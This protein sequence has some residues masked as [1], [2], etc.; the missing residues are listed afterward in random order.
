MTVFIYFLSSEV[1]KV[2]INSDAQHQIEKL[3]DFA[4]F[5]IRALELYDSVR[6]ST[7]RGLLMGELH[8]RFQNLNGAASLKRFQASLS[9]LMRLVT[10]I[11]SHP[12][13]IEACIECAQQLIEAVERVLLSA[14]NEEAA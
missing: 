1:L 10:E 13:H 12:E 7:T 14:T 11:P 9:L 2:K 3:L 5:T 6:S 8:Q 4:Q